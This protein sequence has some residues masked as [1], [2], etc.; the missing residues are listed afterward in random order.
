MYFQYKHT[1]ILC[2]TVAVNTFVTCHCDKKSQIA[3]KN[4][5]EL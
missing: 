1:I 2:F 4:V 5:I 3:N